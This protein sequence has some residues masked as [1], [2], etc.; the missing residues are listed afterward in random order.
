M[1]IGRIFLTL[2]V[3]STIVG[4]IVADWNFTHVFNPEC[5]RMRGSTP[6]PASP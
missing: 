2:A 4:P 5:R 1:K 6:S 3:S